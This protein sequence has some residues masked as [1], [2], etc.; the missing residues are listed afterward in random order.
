MMDAELRTD[1][2]KNRKVVWLIWIVT[3]LLTIW[4][5]LYVVGYY[6]GDVGA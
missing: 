2:R 1:R 4:L 6:V 3:A 5:L